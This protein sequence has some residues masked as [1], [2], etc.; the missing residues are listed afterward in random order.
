MCV[1]VCTLNAPRAP[2]EEV[3]QALTPARLAFLRAA[4]PERLHAHLSLQ[5]FD[6][7]LHHGPPLPAPRRP[8]TQPPTVPPWPA[9]RV[10]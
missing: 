3:V 6:I 1:C 7:M 8:P 9:P 10:Q 2:Q 5:A 4:I